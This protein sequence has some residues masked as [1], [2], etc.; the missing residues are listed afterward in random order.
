MAHPLTHRS[1]F[2]EVAALAIKDSLRGVLHISLHNRSICI[3]AVRLFPDSMTQPSKSVVRR[4]DYL[5][6]KVARRTAGIVHQYL[7]PAI[8][9]DWQLTTFDKII[10]QDAGAHYFAKITY[11][12]MKLAIA[13]LAPRMAAPADNFFISEMLAAH[14]FRKAKIS[15]IEK[16]ANFHY[17]AC[18]LSQMLKCGVVRPN[19][20][21]Y[22]DENRHQ[23]SQKLA[24]VICFAHMLWLLI[25][26]DITSKDIASKNM[27]QAKQLALLHTCCDL[28]LVLYDQIQ[29]AGHTPDELA[30]LLSTYAKIV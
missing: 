7:D 28:A 4:V 11:D 13:Y 19:T 1:H 10:H 21:R 20:S 2:L 15:P 6:E 8:P 14:A 29:G 3:E 25:A 22:A 18:V 23:E 16:E 26:R 12:N 9:E 30:R 27:V 5:A 17:A 24:S